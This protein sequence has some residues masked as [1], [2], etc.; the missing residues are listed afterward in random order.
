MT[1][2]N[3]TPLDGRIAIVTG[4]ARGIGLETA[5]AFK[6]NGATVVSVDINRET[7]MK[8]AE[9]LGIDFIQADLTQSG[10]VR[11]LASEVRSKHGRID[12]AFN[13][14]GIAVSLDSESC[15]DEDWHRVIN[16]NLNAVFYCCREFGKAMLEQGK[17][18]IINTASMS[19]IIS[20]APQPQA[21]YNVSKAGVIMLT[22]SLAGE[23]AKR[24]VRVNSISPGYVGTDMTKPGM[25]NPDWYPTWMQFTPMARVGEPWEIAPAVLFLAS[26]ASSYFTGSNLVMD[27][28]YTVW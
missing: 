10:Q 16:I 14:A 3:L 24:G 11:D 28:G 27:G 7:G 21:A 26:D 13:N 12:I 4:G 23:W 2:S 6:E 17:G 15:S 1:Y 20:N 9:E 25:L 19:G 8:T 22:K 18:S 5:K